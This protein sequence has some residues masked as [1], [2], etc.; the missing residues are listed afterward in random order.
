MTF[1]KRKLP[2]LPNSFVATRAQLAMGSAALV[3]VNT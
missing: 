3:L 2:S 1:V